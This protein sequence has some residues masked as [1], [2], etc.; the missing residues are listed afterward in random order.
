MNRSLEHQLDYAPPFR[1]EPLIAFLAA[2]AIAGREAFR[3]GTYERIVGRESVSIDSG[4]R[5]RIPVKLARNT[6]DLVARARRTF[7]LDS[8]PDAVYDQLRNDRLL[9]P[10]VKRGTRVP[11]AWDPFETAVRAIV[12]QQ[13]SV[14]GATTIMQRLAGVLAPEQLAE[15]D[16]QGMPRKRADA[17]RNLARMV[18]DD[19]SLLSRGT[20]LDESI[21][22]LTA[23][24][25]IGPWTA[26]Y[27]A[28]RA[29]GESDAFPH[30]DLGL[31]KAA[32]ALG[33][34]D[35]AAHAERWRPWRAYAAV[36]LWES[37]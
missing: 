29:L 34:G 13:I 12:G 19:S 31:R 33:I 21:E 28:M 1:W 7:D 35:L 27:V 32:A 4:L 22:R 15:A 10:I 20:T 3:D 8:D 25:G 11:G 14:A 5:M 18:A 17:I 36:T 30:S 16:I 37:L 6:D 9:R 2:R 26:H 23:L 24:P